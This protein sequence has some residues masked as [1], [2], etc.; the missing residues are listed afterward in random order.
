MTKI[1][2][3]RNGSTSDLAELIFSESFPEY[4]IEISVDGATCIKDFFCFCVEL[5][6]SGLLKRMGH[7]QLL[8]LSSISISDFDWVAS[9]MQL[10]GIKVNLQSTP[11]LP[12]GVASVNVESWQ[13]MPD[14]LQL[15]EYNF[16]FVDGINGMSHTITF[17][18]MQTRLH[19]TCK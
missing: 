16:K 4:N 7:S 10:V 19:A 13:F 6:V 14:N 12:I 11:I 8:D 15:E 17:E 9:R 5:C 18:V 1:V 2:D 3:N